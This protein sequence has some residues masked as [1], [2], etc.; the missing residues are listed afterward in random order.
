MEVPE[1][2]ENQ[3][4]NVLTGIHPAYTL[5]ATRDA[6][7]VDSMIIDN[8]LQTLADIALAVASRNDG[9]EK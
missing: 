9:G 6:S 8:F 1:S 4:P 5:S 7:E 2:S 3:R